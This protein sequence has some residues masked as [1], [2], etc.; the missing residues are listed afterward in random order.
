MCAVHI[1][2]LKPVAKPEKKIKCKEMKSRYKQK[3]E[4]KLMSE[5]MKD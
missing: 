4:T 2:D 1:D 5:R 3:V